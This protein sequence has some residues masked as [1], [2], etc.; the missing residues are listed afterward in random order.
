M[1]IVA[2]ILSILIVV[3]CSGNNLEMVDQIVGVSC[4]QCMFDMQGK[5][6]CDLAVKVNTTSYFVSG[7]QIDDFGD[8]HADDGFCNSIRQAKVKGHIKDTEFIVQSIEILP[9]GNQENSSES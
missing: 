9:Q 7:A 5:E 1:K 8:A 4:G 6:G 2:I 3:S